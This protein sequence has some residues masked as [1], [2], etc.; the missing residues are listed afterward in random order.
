[1]IEVKVGDYYVRYP[2]T[3]EYIELAKRFLD[4]CKVRVRRT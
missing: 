1:M 4:A 3:E 2:E